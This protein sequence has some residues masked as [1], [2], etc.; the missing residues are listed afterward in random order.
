MNGKSLGMLYLIMCFL[1]F[2]F[3]PLLPNMS[4]YPPYN[5]LSIS[6]GS[7]EKNLFN[8]Q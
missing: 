5:S 3:Y 4:V 2:F 1:N 6:K 8:N 7:D